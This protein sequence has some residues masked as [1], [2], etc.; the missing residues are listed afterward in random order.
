MAFGKK[1]T[2]SLLAAWP[3]CNKTTSVSTLK[4]QNSLQVVSRWKGGGEGEG[5]GEK[6]KGESKI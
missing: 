6:L 4:S 2:L 5:G 1:V 3:P